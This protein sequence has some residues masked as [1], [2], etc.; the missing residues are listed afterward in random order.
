ME[1]VAPRPN[2]VIVRF[3]PTI[4]TMSTVWVLIVVSV[5]VG[6]TDTT[7]SRPGAGSLALPTQPQ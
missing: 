7:K 6:G 1:G 3:P 2:V 5:D 4:T